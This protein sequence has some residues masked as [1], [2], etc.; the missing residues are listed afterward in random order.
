M[1]KVN[2]MS[3]EL[4]VTSAVKVK[5]HRSFTR[6]R[7]MEN[8]MGYVFVGPTVIGLMVLT[9]FPIVASILLSLTNWNFVA[10]F[11][12]V[13]F[14]GLDNYSNLFSDDIFLISLRNNIIF[15]LVVPVTLAISLILAVIINKK[16]YGKD[17]F[18]IVY[19]MPYISS[20]V[21]VAIVFQ[22]LFHPT[23]GPVNYML[24]SIGV[25]KPPQW[26]ADPSYALYSIMAIMAWIGVGYNLIIYIAGLQSIP[27]DLYEAAEIDGASSFRQFLSITLP[28]I[29]PTTFFLLVTGII[30]SFKA[31]DIIAVLTHGGPANSTSVMV[32][33]LYDTAFTK[34]KTGY[35]SAIAVV[36][37]IC[38]LI[39]TLIQWIGQRKWVNY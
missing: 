20:V 34:L 9:F 1:K 38:V 27:K 24:T 2:R 23:Y 4:I 31:F 28:M 39:I 18:K 29:S 6:Q 17:I 36:L 15:M 33:Y 19:F 32:Y 22:V 30:G 12:S 5:K 26:L 11:N 16:V 21:A 25:A 3:D 35:S 8:L 7:L 37:L 10:G 14:V 13:K